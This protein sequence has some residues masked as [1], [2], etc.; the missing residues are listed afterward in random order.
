MV[1][2]LEEFDFSALPELNQSRFLTLA[3]NSYIERRENILLIGPCGVGKTHL[4]IGLAVAACR[5]RKKVRFMTTGTVPSHWSACP[6]LIF[7]FRF[8]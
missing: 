3:Q 2:T 4:A 6:T 8:V 7:H 5:A 1:K